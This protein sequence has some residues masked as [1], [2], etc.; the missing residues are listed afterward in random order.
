[1]VKIS[2]SCAKKKFLEFSW[3]PP[4]KNPPDRAAK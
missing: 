4:R 3:V 1:M 2:S